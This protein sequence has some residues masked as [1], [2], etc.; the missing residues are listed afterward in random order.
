MHVAVG[1][2]AGVL[3]L[4]SQNQA[5]VVVSSPA[6]STKLASPYS[7][8]EKPAGSTRSESRQSSDQEEDQF[9]L[10]PDIAE[11]PQG[12]IPEGVVVSPLRVGGSK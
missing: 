3:P 9:L 8:L 7:N 6:P 4:F 5:V 1:T 12:F 10:P 2:V 11:E